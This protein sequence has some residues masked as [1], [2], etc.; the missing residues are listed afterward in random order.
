MITAHI[1][2]TSKTPGPGTYLNQRGI[3]ADGKC[4]LSTELSSCVPTFQ[5]PKKKLNRIIAVDY[6]KDNP[7]PG[8]YSHTAKSSDLTK[9]KNLSNIQLYQQ[10]R[11][12]ELHDKTKRDIPGPG[13]YR[14]PSDF[15]YPSEL[16]SPSS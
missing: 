11:K 16:K 2:V 9:Y 7:G 15:G 14:A 12:I 8:S 4:V 6:T 1:Y 3:R 13:T 10:D 5:V